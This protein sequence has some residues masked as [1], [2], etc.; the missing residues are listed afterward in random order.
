MGRESK[1]A[2]K[3]E[4]HQQQ[5]ISTKRKIMENV[6]LLWNQ[7][8]VL[9]TEDAEEAELLNAFFPQPLLMRLASGVPDLRSK[10]RELEKA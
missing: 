4:G 8:H 1:T 6:G 9:V 3:L 5:Y 2:G 7:N 10:R